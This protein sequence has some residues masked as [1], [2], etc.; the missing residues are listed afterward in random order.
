MS[1]R[2]LPQ[3][4]AL[5]RPRAF[6]WD[7]PI[8][9]MERWAPGIQAAEDSA[10]VSIY[11]FIGEDAWTGNGWTAKRVA[12]VLRAI[13]E[14][15]VVLAINSPGGDVF[16][17]IAIYNLFREHKGKVSVKVMGLAASAASVIAMAGDEILMGQGAMMMIHNSWGVT[18]GN[19]FDHE[20]SRD[21]L[22]A[23][24]NAMGGIYAARSGLDAKVVADM[25]AKDTWM[26]AAQAVE[27]GFAD[28]TLADED[29]PPEKPADQPAMARH[30]VDVLMAK[31]GVP[32]SERRALLRE[33]STG[34]TPRAAS[35]P[36][37]HDAGLSDVAASLQ[38]LI[39]TLK[40]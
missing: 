40:P 27:K 39:S 15:D 29:Q 20:A 37:T 14:K 16:E 32:R 34:G 31:Q 3:V 2:Q 38:R 7:A 18:V 11:D 8:E 25:L 1:L 13:G 35:S 28:G 10:T 23:I 4:Q 12:G 9:A 17:G 30:R 36:A 22:M 5:T 33:L 21:V 26:S 6:N 19:Q 24:D